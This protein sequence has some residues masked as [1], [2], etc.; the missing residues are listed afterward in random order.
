M[1]QTTIQLIVV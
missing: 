1:A